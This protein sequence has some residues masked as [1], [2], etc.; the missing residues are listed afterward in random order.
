[1]RA[2]RHDLTIALTR[3]VSAGERHLRNQ[4][5]ERERLRKPLRRA[6]HD[7]LDHAEILA[8]AHMANIHAIQVR[9]HCLARLNSPVREVSA[10]WW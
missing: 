3:D 8:A 4:L 10:H 7:Y 2:F 9:G 5:G 1:M 6:V